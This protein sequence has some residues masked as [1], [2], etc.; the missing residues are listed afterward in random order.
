[1]ESAVKLRSA[2][3]EKKVDNMNRMQ[4]RSKGGDGG[5]PPWAALLGE[6]GKIEVILRNKKIWQGK[7][8]CGGEKNFRGDYKRAIP[9]RKVG[10]LQKKGQKN[11]RV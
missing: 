10:R 9:G 6:G 11:F 2:F 1:M 3:L 8:L 5:G 7:I 4:W